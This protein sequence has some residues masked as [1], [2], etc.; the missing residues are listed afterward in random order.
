MKARMKFPDISKVL[1]ALLMLVAAQS[2]AQSTYFTEVN[3]TV[4]RLGAQGAGF[5]VSF[6]EPFGQN[7][8][9]GAAYITPDTKG[10]Y[11]QLLAAKLSNR[12][13]SRIDYSQPGGNG[14][15]CTAALV[16]IAD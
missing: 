6:V 9:W 15:M 11:V 8:Q 3:K 5:Y 10:L 7:C 14:S 12:R 16:E 4:S 2:H 1:T 13:I